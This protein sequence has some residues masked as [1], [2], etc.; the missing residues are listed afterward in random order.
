MT[1]D[2]GKP[3]KSMDEELI[4][5]LERE[6][7]EAAEKLEFEQAAKLRDK[8]NELK[9]MPEIKKVISG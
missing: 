9:D 5:M 4:G 8:I 2:L 1:N 7:L 6:M 3:N